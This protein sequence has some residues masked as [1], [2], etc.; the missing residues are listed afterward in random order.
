MRFQGVHLCAPMA[1]LLAICAMPSWAATSLHMRF[2][3]AQYNVDRQGD[4]FIGGFG[5]RPF[6][7]SRAASAVATVDH[8]L[9]RIAATT[10]GSAG[11]TVEA[12]FDDFFTISD[13]NIPVN[14]FGTA[15][16]DIAVTGNLFANR[17]PDNTG[18][19][20]ATFKL[21]V[22][23]NNVD[24]GVRLQGTQ[25]GTGVYVGD[26]FGI[27]SGSFRFRFGREQRVDVEASCS[28]NSS[29][30]FSGNSIAACSLDQTI[31][32][33]GITSI[34]P[35]GGYTLG[36]VSLASESGTNYLNDLS[37]PVP[38]PASWALMGLGLAGLA[39]C[40]RRK[41]ARG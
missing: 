10:T 24:T 25:L 3:D 12:A 26:E 23:V 1:V 39:A 29:S 32:W 6:G 13:P 19:G 37:P 7:D 17:Q 22:E 15:S 2:G 20:N 34:V 33:K 14:T 41:A 28:A 11:S 31:V 8:G 5:T 27:Y 4:G 40:T 35:D 30:G 18:S 38:E 9:I 16:F 36:N 21:A